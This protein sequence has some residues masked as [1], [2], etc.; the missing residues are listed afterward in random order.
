MSNRAVSCDLK[1]GKYVYLI[2][3]A[4]KNP[5]KKIWIKESDAMERN[6][7]VGI[8]ISGGDTPQL[9]EDH[10]VALIDTN[11]ISLM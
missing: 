7:E 10:L 5:S 11:I 9:L 6:M 3:R 4:P 8:L 2:C 1:K